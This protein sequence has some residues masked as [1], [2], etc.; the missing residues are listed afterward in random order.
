MADREAPGATEELQS[1]V[2]SVP[3]QV[4]DL[5]D[6]VRALQAVVAS[7]RIRF[8]CPPSSGTGISVR[9]FPASLGNALGGIVDSLQSDTRTA[10][11][12]S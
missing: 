1:L 3:S 12:R 9:R 7:Q 2:V 4:S 8:D 6:E 11:T 5:R 10:S